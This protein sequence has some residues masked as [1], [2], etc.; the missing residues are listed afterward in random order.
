MVGRVPPPSLTCG[1]VPE[2]TQICSHT[3]WKAAAGTLP[4]LRT[5]H[6]MC[7]NVHAQQEHLLTVEPHSS[8]HA[9]RSVRSTRFRE[10]APCGVRAT[11]K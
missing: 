6:H 5:S 9:R 2:T 3:T 1:G 11:T 10:G 4:P 7:R 8:F